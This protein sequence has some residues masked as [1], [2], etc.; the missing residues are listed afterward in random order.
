MQSRDAIIAK[1]KGAI[2]KVRPSLLPG[3]RMFLL[4]PGGKTQRFAIV[5][6][7]PNGFWSRWSTFREQTV[8]QWADTATEW[9]D[10]V[11]VTSHVGFGAPDA[12]DQIDL[13]EISSDQRD[14]VVPSGGNLLWKLYGTRV[15]RERFTIPAP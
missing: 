12:D 3:Y 6:E 10:R 7:I 1:A 2:D 4:K 14:R 8:F 13:Y 9:M 5:F 11:A 15:T